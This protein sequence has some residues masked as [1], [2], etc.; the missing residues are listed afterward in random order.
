MNFNVALFVATFL[1]M[2][3][4]FAVVVTVSR[5]QRQAKDEELRQAAS[6]RGWKFEAVTE[7][8]YR[9]HRWSGT[10]E[11]VSWI[12]EQLRHT[13]GGN[14]RSRR[15][16]ISRWHAAYRPGIN[17]AIIAMGLPTGKEDLGGTAIGAGDGFFAKMAQKAAGFA[18]DKAVDVYF[19]AEAGQQVDAG[20]MHRID[21]E[22]IPGFIL[23]AADTDEAARV[24]ALG[25]QQSLIDATRDKAS[26]LSDEDRPWVLLRPNAISLA[27]ME[28]Y[29]DVT[30]VERF[31]RAGVALTRS[32][33][34][35]HR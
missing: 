11:G 29:R 6:A 15:R 30:E 7:K 35:G 24:L 19:G 27:R 33:K 32:F 3:S 23:M 31:T 13:A 34:F 16:H 25:L 9:V 28:L 20:S 4:L 17:G 14:K 21:A 10:T 18:F 26:A 1:I 22:K 12:A 5:R 2:T 8:G